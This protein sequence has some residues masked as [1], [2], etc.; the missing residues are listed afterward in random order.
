MR[1]LRTVLVVI[2]FSVLASACTPPDHGVHDEP[3]VGIGGSGIPT[4]WLGPLNPIV[5][6]DAGNNQ[7]T[8]VFDTTVTSSHADRIVVSG[9]FNQ[10]V[11]VLY[12]VQHKGSSTWRAANGAG[13][14]ILANAQTA[15]EYL[16][17]GLNSQVE[18]VAGATAPTTS[19]LDIGLIYER[20]KPN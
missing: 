17:Q 5:G 9:F 4:Q 18:I 12:R 7:T 14:A 1:S 19:E 16:V 15:W 10:A 8:V 2:A 13:D 20:A 11:T 6:V 3:V